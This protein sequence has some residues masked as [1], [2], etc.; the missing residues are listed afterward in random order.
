MRVWVI[1]REEPVPLGERSSDRVLR[2]GSL[3]FRLAGRGHD[4]VWWS[5]SF[6]HW[7][8]R[9]RV[10]QDS[11]VQ[12]AE[13]LEVRLLKGCGYRR[14][15]SLARLVDERI[16]T[17][18]FASWARR[19]PFRPDLIVSALPSVEL[20]RAA[21][22]FG[23]AVGVPVVLDMRDMWPDIF[24]EL[25]PTALRPLARLILEPLFRRSHQACAGATAITG[26]TEA[27]VD[28]GVA[29]AGRAR[30]PFDRCF[31]FGYAAT[32]PPPARAAEAERFWDARGVPASG[33]F[34]VSYIGSIDRQRD[35]GTIIASARSLA[36]AGVEARFVICGEGERLDDQ[37]RL[38]ADVPSVLWP[39]WIDAPAIHA[40][41]RR[42]SVGLNPTPDRFDYLASINNKA[43]EYMSAGVPMISSPAKGVLAT[44]LKQEGCG[45]SYGH[46]DVAELTR[47]L[48]QL[49]ADDGFRHGL[50]ARATRVFQERFTAEH[51]YGDMVDYLEQVASAHGLAEKGGVG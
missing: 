23:R 39:G 24:V 3:G 43:I 13:K 37:R 35:I 49:H 9:Q 21:V 7:R 36:A 28:W 29:R 2:M 17:R 32:P 18:K 26:I 11:A 38:S 6:D 14:N 20:C 50:A 34:T 22:V 46:G 25:S 1:K 5:S 41:L 10:T 4:V 51:V 15:V 12:L 16:I 33:V 44:L 19:D 47:L 42:S 27:F 8:K 40:L 48:L 45:L 30:A 31:P